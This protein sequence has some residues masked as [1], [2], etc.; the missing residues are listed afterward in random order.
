MIGVF[1]RVLTAGGA[2]NVQESRGIVV[3]RQPAAESHAVLPVIDIVQ[4]HLA[5]LI[6]QA[7]VHTQVLFPHG[8]GGDHN[9]LNGR[10]IAVQQ[11]KA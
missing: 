10:V 2:E 4:H 1:G 11:G 8:A 6:L 7:D 3:V 5:L 9:L